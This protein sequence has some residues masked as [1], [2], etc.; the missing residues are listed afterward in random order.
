MDNEDDVQPMEQDMKSTTLGNLPVT[1]EDEV[2]NQ[3]HF[4]GWT[5]TCQ[6]LASVTGSL[7]HKLGIGSG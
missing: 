7:V 3:T 2:S 6:S 1:T 5:Q 4:A